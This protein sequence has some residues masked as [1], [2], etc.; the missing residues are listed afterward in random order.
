MISPATSTNPTLAVK[1]TCTGDKVSSSLGAVTVVEAGLVVCSSLF[2]W[3]AEET[4]G[5][6]VWVVRSTSWRVRVRLY[7]QA[8]AGS[9]GPP[10][11]S[12]CGSRPVVALWSGGG[13][14]E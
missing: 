8:R 2:E 7:E 9:R 1:P 3:S 11:C 10:R 12:T 13:G 14:Q 5:V 6:F 4:A